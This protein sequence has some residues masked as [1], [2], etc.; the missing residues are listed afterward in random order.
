MPKL[1][2]TDRGIPGLLPLA[3]TWFL[4]TKTPGLGL[5]VGGPGPRNDGRARAW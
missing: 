2:L 3:R 5:R 1:L 4:D